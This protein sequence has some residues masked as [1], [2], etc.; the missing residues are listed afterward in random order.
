MT[1]KPKIGKKSLLEQLEVL[2]EQVENLQKRTARSEVPDR[3]WGPMLGIQNAVQEAI[4]IVGS[5]EEG[6]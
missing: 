3:I 6:D 5:W 1:G 2:K 4:D